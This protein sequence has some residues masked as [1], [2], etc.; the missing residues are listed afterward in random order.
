MCKYMFHNISHDSSEREREMLETQE[1]LMSTERYQMSKNELNTL[2]VNYNNKMNHGMN[3]LVIL[4]I[5][6]SH[7]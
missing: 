6:H 2:I 5:N 3:Q 4:S 7:K 1:S